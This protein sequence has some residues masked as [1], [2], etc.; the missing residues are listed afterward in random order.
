MKNGKPEIPEP[1]IP[2]VIP[3]QPDQPIMP[4]EPEILPTPEPQPA[5]KPIEVPPEQERM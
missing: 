1:T 2:E 3:P 5:P 4:E